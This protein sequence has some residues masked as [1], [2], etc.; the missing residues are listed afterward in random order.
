MQAQPQHPPSLLPT[1]PMGRPRG[2]FGGAVG[3]GR[4]WGGPG[5]VGRGGRRALPAPCASPLPA[6]A[7]EPF[8]LLG[9]FFSPPLLI[10]NQEIKGRQRLRLFPLCRDL[11][12]SGR[13][14]PSLSRRLGGGGRAAQ[15]EG[16]G[17]GETPGGT[18]GGTP[19]PCPTTSRRWGLGPPRFGCWWP[20]E[21]GPS[22]GRGERA[23][24]ATRPGLG[25]ELPSLSPAKEEEDLGWIGRLARLLGVFA[26]NSW[27][28][29]P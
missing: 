29:P 19:R 18:S 28:T 25:P 14:E 8:V 3:T 4:A 2:G 23:A 9:F 27:L 11:E 6:S 1:T 26:A 20:R 7:K 5:G 22:P 16:P 21:R 24:G 15:V 12:S 17:P 10:P 13:G